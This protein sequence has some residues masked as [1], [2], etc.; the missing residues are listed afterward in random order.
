M[1]IHLNVLR[2]LATA[3]WTGSFS[4][5]RSCHDFVESLGNVCPILISASGSFTNS[6]P[7]D[8]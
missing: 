7:V 4:E 1:H 8:A 3:R 5:K 2:D 6:E